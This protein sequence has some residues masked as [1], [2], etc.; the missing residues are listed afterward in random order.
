MLLI[1]A[2]ALGVVWA[3]VILVVVGLC[4]DAARG[5]RAPRAGSPAPAAPSLRSV[6]TWALRTAS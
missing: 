2:L 4:L 1:A 6:R 3:F 5:D